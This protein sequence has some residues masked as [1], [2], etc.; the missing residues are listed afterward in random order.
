MAIWPLLTLALAAALLYA[1][2][3]CDYFLGDDFD[4]IHSFYGKPPGYLLGLLWSN[5]S[6]DVWKDWGIDPAKGLGYLRPLKIWLLALDSAFWG[7]NPIGFHLTATLFFVAAVWMAARVFHE[8]LPDRPRLAVAGAG[9]AA[10]HPVFAE[11][12]PF[13][14]AREETLSLALGLAALLAFIRARAADRWSPA[15]A[16]LLALALLVKE[17]AVTYVALAAG[18]DLVYG[19]MRPWR[20]RFRRD[21]ALWWPALCVLVAYFA[22]RRFVFGNFLGGDGSELG[23]FS[24]QALR[25]HAHLFRSLA[26]PTLLSIAALPGGALLAAGLFAAPLVAVALFWKR[27]PAERR[28]DLLYTGPV[29]YL[30]SIALYTGVPFATRHHLLP[31]LGL[32]MLVC[33]ALG[34]L[35]DLG[36]LRSERRVAVGMLALAAISFLPAS[37]LTS[38]EY[39]YASAVVAEL[40]ADIESRTH[41]LPSGSNVMLLSVPQLDLTPYYFGWG[42][43]SAL[44]PP[45]TP[46]DVSNRLVILNPRNR[47]LN[48]IE[49]KLPDR[50]D[51]TLDMRRDGAIPDWI[52]QRYQQRVLREYRN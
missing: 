31:V 10:M 7:T 30:A 36:V 26:D 22:L 19:R 18:H 25:F 35:L 15:F 17:S 14:T 8:V 49:T 46:S 42:L 16:C 38:R 44:R 52:K 47:R 11:I 5:E 1:P 37:I 24:W 34:I 21:L 2:N 6:G 13:L 32:V 4:L 39:R 9:V 43:R 27:V 28:R 33:V 20:P 41:E 51:F 45:F 29:W 23:F 48:N 50:I 12:V 3:L 40:R